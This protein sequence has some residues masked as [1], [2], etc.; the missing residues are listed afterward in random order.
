MSTHETHGKITDAIGANALA[1]TVSKEFESASALLRE[2]NRELRADIRELRAE[3]K[4]LSTANSDLRVENEHLKSQRAAAFLA[5]I[6][7]IVGAIGFGVLGGLERDV[8]G[9]MFGAEYGNALC[10]VC[11]TA[12]CVTAVVGLSLKFIGW[13]KK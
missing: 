9:S 6:L 3:N 13:L 11:L 10:L 4:S 5:D 12:T 2:E 1:L 8:F 7:L